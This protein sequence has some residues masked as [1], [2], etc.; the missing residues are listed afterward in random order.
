MKYAIWTWLQ[1]RRQN[2]A[3]ILRDTS[4]TLK[5]TSSMFYFPKRR[6]DHIWKNNNVYNRKA[7]VKIKM[8]PRQDKENITT[9]HFVLCGL[10]KVMLREIYTYIDKVEEKYIFYKSR[11]F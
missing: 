11:R 10:I 5:Y 8:C 4:D 3:N 1:V 2:L 6:R 7:R 9:H